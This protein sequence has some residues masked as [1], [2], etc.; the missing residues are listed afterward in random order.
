MQV[1]PMAIASRAQRIGV[2]PMDGESNRT[3]VIA[4]LANV[5]VAIAKFIVALFSG[6]S[7]MMAEAFHSVADTGNEIFLL[8]AQWRGRE[9]PDEDHPLGHGREPYF[10]ALIASLGIFVTGT[11]LSLRQGVSQLRHP[12]ETEHFVAAYV[13][14]ILSFFIEGS[15][16]LQAYRQINKEAGSL[17][18]RFWQHLDLM[19]DPVARAVFA[20]DSAAITGN[21]VALIGIGLH[22]VTGS[23]LPDG[24]AAIVIALI[25]AYV[26][27]DL[28]RRNRD[29][30]L[31]RQGSP[32][33]RD[34]VRGIIVSQ[35]GILSVSELL[36][37]FIGPRQLWVIA[38]I[39]VD[40]RL[41]AAQIE[42]LLRDTESELKSQSP[43][44]AG[45]YLMPVGTE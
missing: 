40:D 18:R 23:P 25:L 22:Q 13:V 33:I 24:I 28:T 3:V 15:S 14:L 27:F 17:R 32:E 41:G 42:K 44:I 6:S 36:V 12:T 29:F 20:E 21:V 16:L 35:P 37:P 8:I 39:D 45:A 9:P 1:M 4:L 31:G 34:S 10:W 2:I 5:C 19:S 7:A 43:Y 30:I 38:R 11:L 26:A